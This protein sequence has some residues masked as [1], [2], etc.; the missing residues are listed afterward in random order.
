MKGRQ[1]LG[2]PGVLNLGTVNQDGI[3]LD[4]GREV[5]GVVWEDATKLV[6]EALQRSDGP[7]EVR[8]PLVDRL[9]GC[10]GLHG[11]HIPE[12]SRRALD[13]LQVVAL[14]VELQVHAGSLVR[15]LDLGENL[16]ERAHRDGHLARYAILFLEERYL[17]M[18]RA[19]KGTEL[20]TCHDVQG[21]GASRSP[22]RAFLDDPQ[23][24]GHGAFL[25]DAGHL[26]D[27]LERNNK[28]LV[29]DPPAHEVSVLPHVGPNVEN[30]VYAEPRQQVLQVRR[31]VQFP[32][33]GT[34]GDDDAKATEQAEEEVF[35][36]HGGKATTP[37]IERNA[38]DRLAEV[39][40]PE[41]RAI[42]HAAPQDKLVVVSDA[43][44]VTV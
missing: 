16:V 28:A 20:R 1:G 2:R 3:E 23:G 7:A 27:R 14:R 19:E 12:R 39:A 21:H 17:G 37:Q 8:P 22:K 29:S 43:C 44:S 5:P 11:S 18:V 9:D 10:L 4:E 35:E 25:Q 34:P 24:I 15:G 30:A 36:I 41:D 31:G 26:W 13:H 38:S 33:P 6:S 40:D 42:E 32:N